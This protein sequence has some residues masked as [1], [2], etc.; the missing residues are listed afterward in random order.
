M[1][2]NPDPTSEC[3]LEFSKNNENH[4]HS[5]DKCGCFHCLS[6]YDASQISSYDQKN[7]VCPH[8]GI[9]SVVPDSCCPVNRTFLQDMFN[10]FLAVKEF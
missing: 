10:H 2:L 8:C 7:A 9:D 6:I 4:V 1:I 5:S 3:T